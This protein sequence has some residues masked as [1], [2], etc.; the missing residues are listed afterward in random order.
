MKYL[1]LSRVN[2]VEHEACFQTNDLDEARQ[3]VQDR[4]AE[5]GRFRDRLHPEAF[6]IVEVLEVAG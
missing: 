5:C 6:K 2:S 3:H 4:I 1:V